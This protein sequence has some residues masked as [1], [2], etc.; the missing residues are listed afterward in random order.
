M[1][2]EKRKVKNGRLAQP[3]NNERSGTIDFQSIVNGP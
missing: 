1:K 2:N 3:F